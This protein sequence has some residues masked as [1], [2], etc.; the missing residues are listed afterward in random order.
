MRALLSVL[1]AFGVVGAAQAG[2][3]YQPPAERA[4]QNNLPVSKDPLWTTLATTEVTGDPSKGVYLAH[5]SEAVKA[6][7]GHDVTI[8]GYMLQT[9][10]LPPFTH[11]ILARRTPVCAFCPPGEPNEAV[12]VYTPHFTSQT[13]GEVTV[14]GQLKLQKDGSQSLI[15]VLANA[16]II[17]G[18]N[19]PSLFHRR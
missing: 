12:E 15:F 19:E 18:S 7:D 16:Q 13:S 6:L 3:S 9:D 14:R 2:P 5:H 17:A 4:R 11:F 1:M 8:T 10:P